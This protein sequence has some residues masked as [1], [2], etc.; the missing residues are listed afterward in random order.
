M[1]P[2]PCTDSTLENK[3]G[4]VCRDW[5]PIEYWSG[6]LLIP[7]ADLG[8]NQSSGDYLDV[9]ESNHVNENSSSSEA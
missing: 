1:P 5:L 3:T 4:S 2:S 9:K 6:S 7:I 8:E